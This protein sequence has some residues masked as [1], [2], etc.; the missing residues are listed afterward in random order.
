MKDGW[1]VFQ[2]RGE[3]RRL[4]PLPEGWSEFS[5]DQLISLLEH[6]TLLG[7]PRRLIE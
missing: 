4:A 2:T 7:P 6:A 5:D 3:K 1:L